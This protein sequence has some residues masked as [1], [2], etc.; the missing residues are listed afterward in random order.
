MD[1]RN[2]TRLFSDPDWDG[3]IEMVDGYEP[4][5]KPTPGST[6][7]GNGDDPVTPPTVD[8]YIVDGNGCDVHIISKRVEVYDV[9]GKLLRQESIVDYTKSN[10]LGK[11]ASLDNFILKWTSEEKKEVI[12]ELIKE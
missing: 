8:K 6:K 12:R 4:E 11:Y 3:P 7:P 9:D 2:V 10:I 5:H 1:F